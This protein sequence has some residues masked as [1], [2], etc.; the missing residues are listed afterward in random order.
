MYTCSVV[1]ALQE[2]ASDGDV[3]AFQQLKDEYEGKDKW[4]ECFPSDGK[5]LLHR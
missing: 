1:T 2:A 4:K 5:T 3:R